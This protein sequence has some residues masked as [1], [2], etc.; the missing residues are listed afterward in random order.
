MTIIKIGL[1]EQ[2][3]EIELGCGDGAEDTSGAGRE[4][5]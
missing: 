2:Q 3:L 5:G 1:D 4:V